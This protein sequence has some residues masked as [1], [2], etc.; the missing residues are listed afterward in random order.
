MVS[1]LIFVIGKFRYLLT[2][3]IL[4]NPI[5]SEF[6]FKLFSGNNFLT[7]FVYLWDCK[8]AFDPI[9]VFWKSDFIYF[10]NVSSLEGF[11]YGPFWN[12]CILRVLRR[13]QYN[14]YITQLY[15]IPIIENLK[16]VGQKVWLSGRLAKTTRI[17]RD[18]QIKDLKWPKQCRNSVTHIP[19]KTELCIVIESK[20]K[21]IIETIY[22]S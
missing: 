7:A 12:F 22:L 14:V 8:E 21:L 2:F 5:F 20:K 6:G 17:V 9:P 18:G 15:D 11:E 19:D 13:N 1:I 10:E 16:F 4:C 3:P